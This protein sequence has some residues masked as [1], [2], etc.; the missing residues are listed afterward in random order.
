MDYIVKKEQTKCSEC[1]DKTDWV[2]VVAKYNIPLCTAC[3]LELMQLFSSNMFNRYD[4]DDFSKKKFNQ[5]DI[6]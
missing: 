5:G 6:R 2:L 3:S 1:K 4:Y